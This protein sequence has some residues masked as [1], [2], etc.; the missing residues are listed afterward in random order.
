MEFAIPHPQLSRHIGL[1]G[2][3]VAS[4]QDP[5]WD[6]GDSPGCVDRGGIHH[7]VRI[8]GRSDRATPGGA[9]RIRSLPPLE[10]R[11]LDPLMIASLVAAG[12]TGWAIGEGI[13]LLAVLPAVLIAGLI[14]FAQLSLAGWCGLLLLLTVVLRAV[15]AVLGL[16]D[17][18]NFIHYPAALAF[19]VAASYRP[20][21]GD[22]RLPASRW[23]TALLLITALSS[24][25]NLTNPLRGLMF[26]LIVGEPIV[27]IWAIQR[28]SVDEVTE[29]R[30][31]RIAFI[32]LSMQIPLGLWQGS[33]GGW[34]DSVQGTLIGHGAG[35]HILGGLFAL[36]LFVWLAGAVD[37]RHSWLTAGLVGAVAF[38]MM[39]A[40]GAVQVIFLAAAAL[41]AIALFWPHKRSLGS[42]GDGVR[43]AG[44]SASRIATASVLIVFVLTAPFWA[45]VITAGISSR[46]ANLANPSQIEEIVLVQERARSSALQFLLGSG[47]GTSASRAAL[48]L[49]PQYN[50]PGSHFDELPLEPTALALEYSRKTKSAEYGGSA[51]S[52][53]SSMLGVIG[54]LGMVGF[55]GLAFMFFGMYRASKRVGSWLA[56][57]VA[58][59]LI[60]TFGLSFIDNWLEYPEFSVPLAILIGFGTTTR[61]GSMRTTRT[62]RLDVQEVTSGAHPRGA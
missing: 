3:T 33:R 58:A 25:F 27:V 15:V 39:G 40:A 14:L 52:A 53:Q 61:H 46:A 49:T 22:S 35:A 54:D 55:F 47:P 31:G 43:A 60:M 38:G 51:E 7:R 28:W 6:A 18:F 36:G 45:D 41:P 32:G 48:L 8:E 5:R 17:I 12:L 11:S 2:I 9:V 10:F 59:A 1:A 26:I 13:L 16:P 37:R 62:R 50:K 24:I 4:L 57:A 23:M 42:G 20:L 30:V 56:P 34:N 19:A 21:R 29:A 44:R